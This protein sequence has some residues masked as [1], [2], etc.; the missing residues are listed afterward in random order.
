MFEEMLAITKS[1]AEKIDNNMESI[2]SH[3][4]S[5]SEWSKLQALGNQS[6]VERQDDQRVGLLQEKGVRE[7]VE[8]KADEDDGGGADDGDADLAT[9]IDTN[10]A[11]NLLTTTAKQLH[12]EFQRHIRGVMSRFDDSD[13][14]T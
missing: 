12:P 2:F 9:F 7:M 6:I 1:M 3:L 14:A 5:H 8:R 10:L 11:V 4:K 13:L